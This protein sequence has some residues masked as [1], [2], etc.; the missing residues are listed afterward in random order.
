M[1]DRPRNLVPQA[2][3]VAAYGDVCPWC[4]QTDTSE[5][6]SHGV[7]PAVGEETT[8]RHLVSCRVC[9]AQWA[10][11]LQIVGYVMVEEGAIQ[12][13]GGLNRDLHEGPNPPGE[14]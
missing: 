13:E 14:D 2:D 3:Y 7:S 11:Q 12:D 4:R 9:G 6:S 8:V 1:P 5:M 10:D